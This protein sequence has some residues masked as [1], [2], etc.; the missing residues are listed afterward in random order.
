MNSCVAVIE[1]VKPSAP[2]GPDISFGDKSNTILK[3]FVDNFLCEQSTQ[4]K[5]FLV[6]SCQVPLLQNEGMLPLGECNTSL[7]KKRLIDR[8]HISKI[9]CSLIARESACA[10]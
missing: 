5:S 2:M 6:N 7:L 8:K 9:F 1:Y 10:P 4:R 3:G